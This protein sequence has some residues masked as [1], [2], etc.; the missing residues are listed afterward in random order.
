MPNHQ[1]TGLALVNVKNA[2]RN[3][4]FGC[5]FAI[6]LAVQLGIGDTQHP[7][8]QGFFAIHQQWLVDRPG[9]AQDQHQHQRNKKQTIQRGIH[10][11][12]S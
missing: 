9:A 8:E 6:R 10:T 12:S 3:D 2:E 1:P 11:F 5:G 7:L 4:V